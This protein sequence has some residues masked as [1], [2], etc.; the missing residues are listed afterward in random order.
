[1]GLRGPT[2][3]EAV[4]G[5]NSVATGTSDEASRPFWISAVISTSRT[6]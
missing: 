2:L 1:M 5:A 3:M 4:D 6:V